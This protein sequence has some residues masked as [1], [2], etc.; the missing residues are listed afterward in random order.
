VSWVAVVHERQPAYACIGPDLE[1]VVVPGIGGKI[2]SI[3]SARTGHDYVWRQ[4]GR[5]LAPIEDGRTYADADISGLDDCFPTVDPCVVPGGSGDA[6]ELREHGD[7]WHRS[8]HPTVIPPTLHLSSAGEEL[9]YRLSKGLT[10]RG[11]CL[12]VQYRLRTDRPFRYQWTGHLLL[13]AAPGGRLRIHGHPVGRTS[14]ATGGR[15]VTDPDLRWTWPDVPS[16]DGSTVDLSVVEDAAVAVNEKVWLRSPP[17]GT[18]RLE[19]GAGAGD[20]VVTFDADMLPWLAICVDYG[21]WPAAEPAHWVAIEP[22]TSNADA[23]TDSMRGGTARTI[24]PGETHRWW[25]SLTID[26][27][28]VA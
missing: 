1:V 18:A 6:H 19:C 5:R 23:L 24:T 27:G 7:V 8:W 10:V 16:A 2:V 17:D 20:A 9:P 25:W 3:R 21:G 14:F 22:S 11:P 15:L 26:D 4:P 13:R 28:A 12:E